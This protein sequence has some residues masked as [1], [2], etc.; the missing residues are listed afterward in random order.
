MASWYAPCQDVLDACGL[1]QTLSYIGHFI[2]TNE[3]LPMME[4]ASAEGPADVRIINIASEV[5]HALL[6]ADH[7][8]DVSSV[9]FLQGEVSQPWMWRF[10]LRHLFA[11][12]MVNY[13]VAKLAVVLFT[14]ELQRRLDARDVAITCMAVHPGAVLT[15]GATAM[16]RSWL[17]PLTWYALTPAEQGSRH[18]WLAATS[19][20]I[21]VNVGQY[22]G[23]YIEPFG[24]V[25]AGHALSWTPESGRILWQTTAKE[26]ERYMKKHSLTL[27]VV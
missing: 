7:P 20:E 17:Q 12:N 21:R 14:Q 3:I 19:D 16:L 26:V 1:T 8:L 24:V 22:K 6:P 13:A 5:H 10:L 27:Q 25:H 23:R 11:V 2:F 4:V 9:A 15:S 18:T